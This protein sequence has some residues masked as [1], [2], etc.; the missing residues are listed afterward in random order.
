MNSIKTHLS[1]DTPKDTAIPAKPDHALRI[2]HTSDWHLGKLLYNQSRYDEFE[3]F[4]EWLQESLLSHQVDVLIVAGDIFDTMTPSNKAEHL[5]HHFLAQAFKNH[6]KHIIIVAG[7]HD[8]PNSLQKTKE[9]LGVLNTHVIGSATDNLEDELITLY[10]GETPS[11]IIIATPYLRD[12][13]VR[14]SGDAQS[15]EQKN[16]DL[17]Q[18]VA[19]HYHLLANL[20]KQK[21]QYIK[22]T[23]QITIPIIATGHLFVAGSSV[24]S[25]DDG[26]RDLQVGTLG[27]IS[28]SI[29]DDDIDYVALGHIHASQIVA[30][31]SRIRYCGSPI[32]MGFG[33]IGRH[34]QVLIV[35]IAD[36][37]PIQVNALS[38]PIF[39]SLAKISGEL[40]YIYDNLAK[41][42]E[43]DQDIWLEIEYTGSKVLPDLRQLITDAISET[44]LTALSIKN[45]STYKGSL[46]QGDTSDVPKLE[47]LSTTDVFDKRLE[48]EALNDD[49]KTALK[50]AYQTLLKELQET[51][52]KAQ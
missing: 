46:S 10:D 17:L 19:D 12:R 30:K 5:Y 21:Q 33:E 51:D 47:M 50:H 13:D 32:A 2:L 28:A 9:V 16:S 45:R 20:A 1:T 4:L 26:M 40:D 27:Q 31:Q 24:S 29:F 42:A 34:K 18:G 36:G 52:T 25:A 6:I 23:Y 14:T 41:L 38:V 15:I 39:Q 49:E 8:S 48:K 11:A 35:D 37:Q 22:D 3:R 43:Y 44:R 7:N